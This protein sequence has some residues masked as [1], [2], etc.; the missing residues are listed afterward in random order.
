MANCI[1]VE[2]VIK[3]VQGLPRQTSCW[4]ADDWERND[5]AADAEGGFRLLAL[6]LLQDLTR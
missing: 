6:C 4:C 5:F 3:E 2:K 1:K